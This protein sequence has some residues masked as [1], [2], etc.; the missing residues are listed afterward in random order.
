MAIEAVR[1][2]DG[3]AGIGT[4]VALLAVGSALFIQERTVVRALLG[5]KA[6]AMLDKDQPAL[7]SASTRKYSSSSSRVAKYSHSADG[8]TA[9]LA[10]GLVLLV[11]FSIVH[12]FETSV[13]IEVRHYLYD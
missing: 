13:Q 5:T 10:G 6:A 1:T 9:F 11:M 3:D 7:Y 2:G 4:R 12:L 8:S